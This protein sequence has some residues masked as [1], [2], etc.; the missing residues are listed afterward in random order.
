M[1]PKSLLRHP[2]VI[3]GVADLAEGGFKPVLD[4]TCDPES[5]ERLLLCSG[6]VYYDLLARREETGRKDSAIVRLELLY[7]FPHQAIEACLEKYSRAEEIA[8]VQEEHKN[9]GAWSYMR[10]RFSR[11]FPKI[12]LRYI[13]R[14]ESATSATGLYKQFQAEQKK[15]IEDAL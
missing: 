10:E 13:G 6:K 12:E 5:V 1:T 11:H 4:D 14:A 15:L 8:W 3:S 7:P 9:Y 2:K